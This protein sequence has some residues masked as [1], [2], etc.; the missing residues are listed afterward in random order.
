MLAVAGSIGIFV[1]FASLLLLLGIS[2]GRDAISLAISSKSSKSMFDD[3]S[4]AMWQVSD[5]VAGGEG[6][7]RIVCGGS[8][9]SCWQ[10]LNFST[11]LRT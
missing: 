11:V 9:S 7:G 1:V 6:S 10:P 4:Q 3:N 5:E 2:A 8:W